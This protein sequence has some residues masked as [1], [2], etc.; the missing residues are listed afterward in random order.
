MRKHLCLVDQIISQEHLGGRT[1]AMSFNLFMPLL[2]ELC[3][4]DKA[5][6]QNEGLGNVKMDQEGAKGRCV[7][8]TGVAR[9]RNQILNS[10]SLPPSSL[11]SFLPF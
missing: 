10:F 7:R 1:Q 6:L 2:H 8:G 4:A 3:L 9:S 5:R 11:P